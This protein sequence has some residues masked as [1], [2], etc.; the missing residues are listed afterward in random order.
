MTT[1]PQKGFVKKGREMLK[2]KKRKKKKKKAA[3]KEKVHKIY[4]RRVWQLTANEKNVDSFTFEVSST[5]PKYFK[6]PAVGGN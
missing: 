6:L 5:T 4:S 3:N 2:M 1:F